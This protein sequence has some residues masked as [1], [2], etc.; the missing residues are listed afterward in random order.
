MIDQD[1]FPI[2]AQ[3][4]L[5]KQEQYHQQHHFQIFHFDLSQFHKDH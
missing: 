1:P 2:L 3:K 5:N 4:N